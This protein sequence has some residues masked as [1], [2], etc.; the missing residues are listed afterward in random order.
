MCRASPVVRIAWD[1]EI[2]LRMKVGLR[3]IWGLDSASSINNSGTSSDPNIAEIRMY[4]K[5]G[6]IP[7]AYP[8]MM[9]TRNAVGMGVAVDIISQ[10]YRTGLLYPVL[11][12]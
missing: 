10:T 7:C 6:R 11:Q 2:T 3:R 1:K 12:G 4:A 5:A 9:G 8:S